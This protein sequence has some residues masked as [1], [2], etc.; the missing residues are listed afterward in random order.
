MII[1]SVTQ[2]IGKMKFRD[3]SVKMGGEGQK[4]EG[5]YGVL[6]ENIVKKCKTA[7]K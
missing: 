2:L 5:K 7:Q 6:I 3:K 4:I 1:G